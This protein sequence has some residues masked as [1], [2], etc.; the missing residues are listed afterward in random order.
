[1]PIRRCNVTGAYDT[2]KDV[3]RELDAL[4]QRVCD[5]PQLGQDAAND[6]WRQVAPHLWDLVFGDGGARSIRPMEL[7]YEPYCSE[8]F[9]LEDELQSLLRDLEDNDSGIED[10]ED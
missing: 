8:A 9:D 1:M 7:T 4:I 3:F 6:A 5:H 2:F 10:K